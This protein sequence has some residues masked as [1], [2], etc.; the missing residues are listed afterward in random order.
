MTR[1]PAGEVGRVGVAIA[2]IE[3]M[4]I[5][6]DG[7]PARPRLHLHDDQLHGGDSAR[8]PARRRQRAGRFLERAVG[9]DPERHPEGVRR[10]RNVHLSAPA[11]ARA[12]D[13]HLRVL[14]PRGAAVEHD[15]DLRV[16]H[17]R[18][19][20]DGRAGDR[21]HAVE[22]DRL[23]RGGAGAGARHRRFCARVCPSSSTPTRTSSRRSRSSGRPG[24]CGPRSPATASARRDPRSW[25]LRFHTQTA[26][27]TLTAQ[28][29]DVNVVRVALQA[30]SAVL[31]GHAV[32]PHQRR[33]RGARASDRAVGAPGAAHAAGDRPR[34]GRGRRRRSAGRVRSWSK[35]GRTRCVT[36]RAARSSNK[37]DSSGGR[38]RGD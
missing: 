32:A 17:P 13:R 33:R 38:G 21:I 12:D 22:R 15:L 34:D 16:P 6:I 25:R 8:I 5:L 28:Q 29:T 30:L 7:H 3:D 36:A 20:I 24:R 4:R 27:S 18:G 26:G 10:P 1:W 37:V 23:R 19:R 31:G 14:R 9:N 11:L 35:T 2:T